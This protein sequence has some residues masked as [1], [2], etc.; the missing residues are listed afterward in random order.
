[1]I[2]T[3]RRAGCWCACQQARAFPSTDF[4]EMRGARLWAR[5]A[6]EIE[7]LLA[8]DEGHKA[9]VRF[10]AQACRARDTNPTS[11]N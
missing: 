1:M 9:L 10:Q 5:V 7:R 2:S 6:G 11:D 4:E 3:G 8:T